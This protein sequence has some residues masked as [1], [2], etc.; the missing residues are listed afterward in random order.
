[1]LRLPRYEGQVDGRNV[2]RVENTPGLHQI[3]K[4]LYFDAK[5]A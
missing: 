4:E 1:M 2:E 3:P 5:T